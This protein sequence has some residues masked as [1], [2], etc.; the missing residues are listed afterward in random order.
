MTLQSLMQ[1][2]Q[3]KTLSVAAGIALQG[4]LY[5]FANNSKHR[6]RWFSWLLLAFSVIATT[7]FM[8]STWK[9]QQIH[10]IQQNQQ[11]ANQSWQAEQIRYQIAELNRQ[12]QISLNSADT[13]TNTNYRERGKD[14]IASLEEQQHRRDRLIV[15]LRELQETPQEISEK[16]VFEELPWLRLTL[17]AVTSLIIDLSAIL[18][19]GSLTLSEPKPEKR[20]LTIDQPQEREDLSQQPEQ[21]RLAAILARIRDGEYGEYVPVKQ[22]V[23]TEPVRHPELKA[24]IDQLIDE[25]VLAKSGNRY[26]HTGFDKHPEICIS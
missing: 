23:A 6:I 22:I 13:D 24:G 8:E 18:A 1:G 5:L 10:T 11:Q 21:D 14:T 15:E 2:W 9:Q 17:F 3:A 20:E 19:F 16:A 25:G 4:C 26:R 12:I 7:W